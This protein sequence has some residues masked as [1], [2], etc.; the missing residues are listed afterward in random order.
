MKSKLGDKQRLLHILDACEK[1]LLATKDYDEGRFVCDFIITAAVCNF[2]MIIGEAAAT[3]TKEFKD[4]NTDFDWRLMKGMRNIIVHQYFGVDNY[5]MFETVVND[6][7]KLKNDCL[8][9]LKELDI[10]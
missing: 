10:K 2:I 5:K 9:A 1:I 7:P 3:I 8:K 4:H 6:I